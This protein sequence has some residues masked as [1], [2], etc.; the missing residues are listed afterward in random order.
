MNARNTFSK[1]LFILDASVM[2][3]LIAQE[4]SND[5]PTEIAARQLSGHIQNGEV[6][7]VSMP[8]VAWEVG[9]WAARTFPHQALS[10]MS[11]L[12]SF[13]LKEHHLDLQVTNR[14]FEIMRKCPKVSFY[15]A[16]Y[17][18]LAMISGGILLTDDR[19]YYHGTR[20]LGHI[21]LLQDY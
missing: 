10:I 8:V 12:G 2:I 1:P 19:A 6:D 9:N 11:L 18:A 5:D 13:G 15:D 3:K 17:H 14:T 20:Y 7:I 4:N 21:K 16:S